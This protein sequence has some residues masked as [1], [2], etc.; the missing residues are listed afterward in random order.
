VRKCEPKIERDGKKYPPQGQ[1]PIVGAISGA[2]SG[3]WKM[4]GGGGGA[5]KGK[6]DGKGEL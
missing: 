6:G 5:Q 4:V 3:L 2:V 1:N